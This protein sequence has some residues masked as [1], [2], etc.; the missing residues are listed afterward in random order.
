MSS[1]RLASAFVLA[2][3]ATS[4]A[5]DP[6]GREL[7]EQLAPSKRGEDRPA[8][9]KPQEPPQTCGAACEAKLR[10]ELV[11]CLERSPDPRGRGACGDE[12]FQ[13]KLAACLAGCSD[14]PCAAA[15]ALGR[16][17][18]RTCSGGYARTES[19]R[20]LDGYANCLTNVW[21]NDGAAATCT[22]NGL[23]LHASACE[24]PPP[25]PKPRACAVDGLEPIPAPPGGY[26]RDCAPLSSPC[27]PAA[28]PTPVFCLVREDYVVVQSCR[29]NERAPEAGPVWL[30]ITRGCAE[31]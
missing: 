17:E 13:A 11:G 5:C 29:V 4:A 23:E 14:D 30:G 16:Y 8:P 19:I 26:A 10:P 15:S 12:R 24:A 22:W 9:P 25:P 6:Y 21:A 31:R 18:M 27:D 28:A 3:A 7:V 20:C 2:I 1:R